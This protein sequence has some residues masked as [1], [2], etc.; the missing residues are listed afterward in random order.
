MKFIGICL[1]TQDVLTLAKFYENV[2]G[3]QASGDAVHMELSTAK[4]GLTIF[5]VEGME[6][7]A[8]DSTLGLGTGNVILGFEVDDVDAEYV[9]IHE[10]DVE[11]VMP[12]KTHPWGRRSFWFRDPDGNIVDFYC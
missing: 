3:V 8:P 2:L 10:L 1:I 11:L 7:M 5:S 6:A 12:P 4:T 9:R